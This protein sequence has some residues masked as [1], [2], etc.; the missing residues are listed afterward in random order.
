MASSPTSG[1][2]R[3]AFLLRS[4]RD[5]QHSEIIRAAER[6]AAQIGAIVSTSGASV[7]IITSPSLA[8]EVVRKHATAPS[9]QGSPQT[10][11][12]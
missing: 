4:H 9:S 2:Q 5:A 7:A 10:R 11:P 12:R 8:S 1:V 3:S 6:D